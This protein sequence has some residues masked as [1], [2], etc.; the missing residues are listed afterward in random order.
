MRAG[1]STRFGVP[2]PSGGG[3]GGGAGRGTG[4]C[5]TGSGAEVEGVPEVPYD[6]GRK[7]STEAGGERVKVGVGAVLGDCGCSAAEGR[8]LGFVGDGERRVVGDAFALDCDFCGEVCRD[9]PVDLIFVGDPDRAVASGFGGVYSEVGVGV[10]V[11]SRSGGLRLGFEA[12]SEGDTGR[13]G[14]G[15]LGLKVLSGGDS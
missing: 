12:L 8:I 11:E 9:E 6:G 7:N 13:G 4:C 5:P 14:G 10:G 15:R 3:D 2:P 1:S